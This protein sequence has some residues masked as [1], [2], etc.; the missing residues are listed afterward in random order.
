MP[1]LSALASKTTTAAA[2]SNLILVTPQ[3]TQGYQPLNRPDAD[4][5]P[6]TKQQP[7]ALLFHYEGEQTALVTSD[8]TDHFVEDNSAIQDQIALKPEEISTQGFI[9]ELNDVVPKALKPIKFIADKL[10]TVTAYTPALTET[11]LIAYQ[12]AFFLYQTAANAVNAAVSAWSSISSIGSSGDEQNVVS[13]SG[14]S[15][16]DPLSGRVSGIQNK[17]QIAF[18]Q[19]YGY[20]RNRTL[21]TV[22]TPWAVF[23]NM[24]IKTLRAI[25][26]ADTRTLSTFEVTFKMIRTA[27]TIT[28]SVLSSTFQGR[29]A[30]QASSLV[31]LGTSSPAESS[32]SFSGALSTMGVA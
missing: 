24:A 4:G 7:P 10:T 25:Q 28:T 8:I 31:D 29:A 21:F 15:G 32:T 22:Q 16:F 5:S 19:F 9:G 17:Q 11:A 23:Q 30:T 6:S 1:N 20:W 27:S 13:G 14:L 26:D 12:Q 3:S 18:Q 2:L